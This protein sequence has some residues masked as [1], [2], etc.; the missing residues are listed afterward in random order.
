M[1]G[2][3][4]APLAE[5]VFNIAT[6]VVPERFFA[7]FLILFAAALVW[8]AC[9]YFPSHLPWLLPFVFNPVVFLG[10]WFMA[11]WYFRGMART[12]PEARPGRWRQGFF[13]F[14]LAGI[15]FVLQTHFE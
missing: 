10:C 9:G 5:Y 3:F 14:G 15:Y 13:I 1:V 7:E 12:A 4:I 11:L 2:D 6:A 8:L